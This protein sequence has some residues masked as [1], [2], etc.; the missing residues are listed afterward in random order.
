M[1]AAATFAVSRDGAGQRTHWRDTPPV[2][3][4]PTA[5]DRLHLLHAA[6]GPLGGDD[7]RLTGTVGAACGL[8]VRSAGA[9][10][11]QPGNTGAPADFAVSLT[12]A[13]GADLRW[14]PQA[15][16]VCAG[17]DFRSALR[18]ELDPEAFLL[19]RELVVLGRSREAGGR[20]AGGLSVTVGGRPLLCHE[21]LLDGADTALS[22]P[23]GTGGHRVSG[24][25]VVAG[26]GVPPAT[27]TAGR[28]GDTEWAVLPLAGPGVLVL[29]LGDSVREVDAALDLVLPNG[30]P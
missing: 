1:R 11:V 3:L 16:V 9:T 22:G 25:A 18:A 14:T 8:T 27:E 23:A 21:T 28:H 26:R 30:N 20:Y 19:I 12:L 6:G 17:A 7:L 10:V 13:A 15:T 24:T 4:R 29:A 2:V 5:T